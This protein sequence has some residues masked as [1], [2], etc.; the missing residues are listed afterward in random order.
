M[1]SEYLK[2]KY[3]DVKPDAPVQLTKKQKAANWWHYHKWPLLVG[4]LLMA[5]AID[6]GYNALGFGAIK[7]DYQVAYVAS[8]P[9]DDATIAAVESAF[10]SYGEDC[11]GDGRVTVQVH[12]YVDM[13]DSQDSDAARYAAAAKVK[14]MADMEARESYFFILD[15]PETFHA[16]YQILADADGALAERFEDC[17]CYPWDGCPALATINAENI[18]LSELY[19]ARRGFWGDRVCANRAECD[20]LWN[21][22]TE[23]AK[24]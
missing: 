24:P 8:A 9:L 1:A 18:E 7:P 5:A 2:W 4:A 22:L 15:D 10:A 17:L 3:R 20:A 23:G 13:A 16:N 21:A 14:L 19:F 11:N 6:I 12:A